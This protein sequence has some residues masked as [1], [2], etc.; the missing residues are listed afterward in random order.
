MTATSSPDSRPVAIPDGIRSSCGRALYLE[1]A[2]RRGPWAW[3]RL[4]WFIAIATLRDRQLPRPE[5]SG[6]HKTAV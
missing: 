4:R 2:Q 5:Q 1:L 3:L 6:G